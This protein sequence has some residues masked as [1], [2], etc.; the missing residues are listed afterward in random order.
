MYHLRQSWL[1]LRANFTAGVAT[2]TT[3]TLTLTLLALVGMVTLNL[4]Q[5][6]RGLERDVQITA[7]LKPTASQSASSLQAEAVQSALSEVEGLSSAEFVSRDAAYQQL[8]AEYAAL[9]DA[10][11]LVQNPL[12]DRIVVKVTDATKLE[13]I[14]AT[15]RKIPG[16]AD[17]E[18]GAQFVS[19]VLS[20]LFTVRTAGYVLVGLL[21]LNT[22]LNILNTIR[23]AMFARR[24][25]IQVMRMI[26]ATRGFIRAPYVLEGVG[27]ALLSSLVTLLLVLPGYNNLASRVAELV[28]YVPVIRDDIVT[29]RVLAVVT[30]LGVLLGL[31]GSLFATNRYLR[32]AE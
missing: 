31:F 2:L 15:I 23:V 17:L 12:Q 26:G 27:L 10:Q 13:G 7:F 11:K 8:V 19:T 14:A 28:P 30:G 25:E 4:E 24:D 1:A 32:E 6:V 21:V 29:L 5:I 3:M 22:L 18:Y 9:G 16:V 20:A